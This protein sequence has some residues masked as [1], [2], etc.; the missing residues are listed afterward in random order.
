M[1]EGGIGHQEVKVE[2]E[3][4]STEI[5]LKELRTSLTRGKETGARKKLPLKGGGGRFWMV[6]H[7]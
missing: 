2:R 3:K 6:R 4:H 7:S 1:G 5:I